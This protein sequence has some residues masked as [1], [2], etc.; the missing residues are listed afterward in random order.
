LTSILST[1]EKL[2]FF[3]EVI[4]RGLLLIILTHI[5]NH[6]YVLLLGANIGIVSDLS[7]I[8]LFGLILHEPTRV[9]VGVIFRAGS[10]L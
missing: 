2:V 9:V 4:V 8:D 5:S 1:W 10:L 6:S 3:N 7:V